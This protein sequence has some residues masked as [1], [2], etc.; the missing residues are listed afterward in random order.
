MKKRPAAVLV[1]RSPNAASI[2][3]R[4]YLTM[5]NWIEP[6]GTLSSASNII[7]AVTAAAV[8]AGHLL[9]EQGEVARQLLGRRGR[10]RHRR[11]LQ[12]LAQLLP[13]PLLRLL[14]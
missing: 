7:T 11:H 3:V 6:A 12:R 9:R 4:Q 10:Q 1:H 13:L 5:A 14:L 2:C 8:G